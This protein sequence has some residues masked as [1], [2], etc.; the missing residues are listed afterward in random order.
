MCYDINSLIVYIKETAKTL[1]DG[2]ERSVTS[3]DM[4]IELQVLRHVAPSSQKAN[5]RFFFLRWLLVHSSLIVVLAIKYFRVAN[6][7]ERRIC[8]LRMMLVVSKQRRANEVLVRNVRS[9]EPRAGHRS[10]SR[11]ECLGRQWCRYCISCVLD[12]LCPPPSVVPTSLTVPLPRRPHRSF[13]L[14]KRTHPSNT[15][16]QFPRAW[17]RI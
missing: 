7:L 1:S 4:G 2:H 14:P 9:T 17:S 15:R 6:I 13:S 11:N 3:A 10:T 8:R 5:L 16:D 12:A